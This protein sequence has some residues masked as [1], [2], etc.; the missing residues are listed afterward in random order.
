[1]QKF[2][3]E[4]SH[5]DTRVNITLY[6]D[7]K[8]EE[9][10]ERI[11]GAF[12]IF[13]NLEQRFSLFKPD[14]EIS[15]INRRA[16]SKTAAAS[17]L[18]NI[19]AYAINIAGETDGIFNP[20]VGKATVKNG[21]EEKIDPKAFLKILINQNDLTI[22]L[23]PNSALDLNSIIKGT[24]IDWAMESL[25]EDNIM[26]EAGGDILVKGLPPG[27]DHWQIGIRDPRKPAKIITIVNLKAGAICTSGNYFRQESAKK[28]NRRHLVNTKGRLGQNRNASMSVI[29]NCAREADALS[30]AAFFM[31]IEKAVG[32]VE[33]H[34]GCSCL[35]I[36][37][38]SEIYM[39]PRM[40]LI[41]TA[42][43]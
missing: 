38:N 17:D 2:F 37:N 16:G 36:D 14:S 11:N 34:T 12:Y 32:F 22:T 30:T 20:L 15:E 13:Q 33:S 10:L 27:K 42:A 18:L 19:T 29:A 1:M 5:M 28:E 39:S 40:R 8:E 35:I 21:A 31:P 6:T 43:Q 3:F 41:F 26:I 25:K 23:P 7:K 24:A 4:Q 9:F